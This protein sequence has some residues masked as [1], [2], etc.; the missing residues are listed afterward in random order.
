MSRRNRQISVFRKS[1]VYVPGTGGDVVWEQ[2]TSSP[3]GETISAYQVEWIGAYGS[4]LIEAQAQGVSESATVRMSYNPDVYA[5]LRDSD[6]IITYGA[7][8]LSDVIVDGQ[9]DA[10]NQNL[11]QLWGGVDDVR[12]QGYEMELTVMRYEAK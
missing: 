1:S 12:M 3:D 5:A 8:T 9:P 2:V 6:C 4:R 10:A 7:A 11:W